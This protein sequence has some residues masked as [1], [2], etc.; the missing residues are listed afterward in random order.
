MFLPGAAKKKKTD[1]TNRLERQ[2]TTKTMARSLV[3][4]R[5]RFRRWIG[6]ELEEEE[7][8]TTKGRNPALE[9]ARFR[10]CVMFINAGSHSFFSW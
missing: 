3:C 2:Q 1:G 7:G 6:R 5:R 8:F 10:I 9:V 4:L